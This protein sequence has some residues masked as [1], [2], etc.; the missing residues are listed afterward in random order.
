[1]KL[2][3]NLHSDSQPNDL[4]FDSRRREWG[5]VAAAC[6]HSAVRVSSKVCTHVAVAEAEVRGWWKLGRWWMLGRINRGGSGSRKKASN[7]VLKGIQSGGVGRDA[8]GQVRLNMARGLPSASGPEIH[9][10]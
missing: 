6:L 4:S 8:V 2:F 10:A 9:A 3:S 5:N 1:M 7:E